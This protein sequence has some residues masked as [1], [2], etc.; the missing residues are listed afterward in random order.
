MSIF[1]REIFGK[2]EQNI[3]MLSRLRENDL[4]AMIS[5]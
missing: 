5:M 2:I 4:P 1:K 3:F